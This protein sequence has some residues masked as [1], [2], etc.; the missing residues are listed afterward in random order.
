MEITSARRIPL[1]KDV[2]L[3]FRLLAPTGRG[4]LR[5][6]GNFSVQ[7]LRFVIYRLSCGGVRGQL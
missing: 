1:T 5:L 7:V 3:G 2:I 6:E 4:C